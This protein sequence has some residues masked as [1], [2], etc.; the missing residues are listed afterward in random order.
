MLLTPSYV[1]QLGSGKANQTTFPAAGF[2][3]D[4]KN[5]IVIIYDIIFDFSHHNDEKL[6]D[7]TR[8]REV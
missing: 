1:N 6:W 5:S 8:W 7:Q 3:V 4:S 2:R